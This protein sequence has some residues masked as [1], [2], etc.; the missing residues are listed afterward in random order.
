MIFKT[1]DTSHMAIKA[2][3]IKLFLVWTNTHRQVS[4]TNI[5]MSSGNLAL[6]LQIKQDDR[7]IKFWWWM[8]KLGQT[9]PTC[10]IY[11]IFS[12]HTVRPKLLYLFIYIFF[13]FHCRVFE[14][15]PTISKSFHENSNFTFT[16][17]NNAKNLQKEE[18]KSACSIGSKMFCS[19]QTEFQMKFSSSEVMSSDFAS[20]FNFFLPSVEQNGNHKRFISNKQSSLKQNK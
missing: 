15:H 19:S 9:N 3:G 4:L 11:L 12:A 16:I 6:T 13:C 20:D 17:W 5:S 8:L 7:V 10:W 2:S 14:N 1:R 18:R